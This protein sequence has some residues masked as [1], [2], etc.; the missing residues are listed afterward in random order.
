MSTPCIQWEKITSLEVSQKFMIEKIENIE[1]KV[2][3]LNEKF[4]NLLEK[5]ETKFAAKWVEWVIKWVVGLIL[6]TVFGAIIAQ[7]IVK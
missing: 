5:L 7:V 6:I 3:T 2:D 1:D 4:D